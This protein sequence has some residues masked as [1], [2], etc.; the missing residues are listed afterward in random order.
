MGPWDG[1]AIR[2]D[3]PRIGCPC[4]LTRLPCCIY[5]SSL[6]DVDQ[7]TLTIEV[8]EAIGEISAQMRLRFQESGGP[9]IGFVA[10]ATLR[11]LIRKGPR[12]VSEL[13]QLEQVTPQAISLRIR[14]LVE[15]GLLTRVT[16]PLDGRR[17]IL[18]AT[19]Q[20][21]RA[22]LR[23]EAGARRALSAAIDQFGPIE[24]E[25]LS[26]AVPLLLQIARNLITEK[27]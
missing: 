27:P 15:A 9:E 16:D 20:G 21:R 3:I 25:A 8:H 18:E 19:R 22:V 7:E 13:A 11:H 26:S 2:T 10:M 23:A 1:A 24:R 14:P 5:V 6:T 17:A 4:Q 12:T